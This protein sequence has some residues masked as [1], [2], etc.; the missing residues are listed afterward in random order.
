VGLHL[1][2]FTTVFLLLIYLRNQI[3]IVLLLCLS[4]PSYSAVVE[5]LFHSAVEVQ[6]QQVSDRQ[7]AFNEAL[8]KVLLKVNGD[9]A[10]I[11]DQQIQERF[12]PAERF[13]QS[14]SY[15]ENS[16]YVDYLA[17]QKSEL[18]KSELDRAELDKDAP[19]NFPV[20]TDTNANSF[21]SVPLPYLLEVDFSSATLTK[22]MDKLGLPVWGN[23]R[24]DIMLWGI[25]ESEGERQ[26]LGLAEDNDVLDLIADAANNY[27]FP[28]SFPQA[29]AKDKE[30]VR[31]SDLWGLFPDAINEAKKR[32]AANGNVM[33]RFY[34]S[35][36]G[37]WSANWFFELNE[38]AYSGALHDASLN[39][40]SEALVGFISKIL[41][42]RYSIQV[43]AGETEKQKINLEVINI[44]AFKDYIDIQNFLTNLA[45]VKS[46][47]IS[48]LKGSTLSLL[49][50]LNGSL[51]RFNE[52]LNL[53]GKLK[54][55]STSPIIMP[56][57]TGDIG[58]VTRDIGISSDTPVIIETPTVFSTDVNVVEKYEWLLSSENKKK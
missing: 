17:F 21:T 45:P 53:S 26:F 11:M 23:V 32:Y 2:P 50:E 57:V 25:I 49:V 27:A 4:L 1:Y 14:F 41:S 55:I 39:E 42:Q 7:Q 51:S 36:S 3:V 46:L 37:L 56:L 15:Q 52:Y 24:P 31:A 22:E 28:V 33:V 18:D 9:K 10:L 48:W 19:E 8:I 16:R 43:D 6:S 44:N 5:G 20:Q 12:F 38:L 34:Q 40:V 29:D 13:V 54:Y 47:S 35:V 58:I 30:L